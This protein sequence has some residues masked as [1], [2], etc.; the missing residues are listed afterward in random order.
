MGESNLLGEYLRAR[1]EL[2]QP[3]SVGLSTHGTR[4]VT[5]LRREEVAMLAGISSDYYLRLEQ[6]RDRNPSSQVLDSLA[7]VLQLDQAS[8]DY[9]LSLVTSKSQPRRRRRREIVPAGTLQ[10]IETLP[11]PAYVF[12]R[13]TDVLASNRLAQALSPNLQVGKNNLRTL[14]L[15]PAEKALSAD[16]ERNTELLVAVFRQSVGTDIDDPRVVELVGELSLSSERFCQLWARR[17]VA[18]PRSFDIHLHHPQV[19]DLTLSLEKLAIAGTEGQLLGIYHAE[20]ASSSAE[21][22]ALLATLTS[23][24]DTPVRYTTPSEHPPTV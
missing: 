3:A 11:L 23:S 19:G 8:A 5:G 20:P 17:D 1:R 18:Q 21:K 22:L 9:L 12:G 2:V 24:I 7:R 16:W 4:R 6:G 15:D 10:L 14:F 13:Y